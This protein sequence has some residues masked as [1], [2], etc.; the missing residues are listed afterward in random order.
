MNAM[1]NLFFGFLLFALSHLHAQDT[2]KAQQLKEVVLSAGRIDLP[3]SEHSRTIEIISAADI[4]RAAATNLADLLQ[5]VVGVDI[6]RRGAGGQQADLYIRGGSFDQT[7]LLI[8]GIKVEDPQT[9]HHTLNMALPLVLIERIEVVKGPSARIFGQNAFTGAINIV[10]KKNLDAKGIVQAGAGSFSQT[11]GAVSLQLEQENS[12]QIFH[13][14]RNTSQ[15]YR[16]NTDFKNH[17]FFT[18]ATFNKAKLP[19]TVMATFLDRA[20]GANGFYATPT[21]TEQYEETQASLVSLQT[22][23]V[24]NAWTFTPSVFWKRNQDQYIY[25]RN[26]PSVYRNLHLSNKVGAALMATFQS[27]LGTTGMGLELAQVSIRSNNLGNR[28][29]Q[30]WNGFLEQRFSFL[31]QRLDVTPGVALNYFSDFN[32]HAFPGIDFGYR[33][34]EA[35]KTYANFGYTYRIPTYTDL[36]YEDSTTIGNENLAPEDAFSWELGL[37]YTA[38]KTKAAAAFFSRA[39]ENLI[40]YVKFE[41]TDLWAAQNFAALGTTGF[42]ISFL[43]AFTAFGLPQKITMGYT[44]IDDEI[45]DVQVPF[46]RYAINSLKHQWNT[47]ASMNIIS[48]LPATVTYRYMERTNGTNY[49]VLDASLQY[50]TPSFVWSLI[51]NNLLD[52][53]FSETN[54]VPAPG[55]N[56]MLSLQYSFK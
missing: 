19:I 6:R 40:D 5:S 12:D 23:L 47:T 9:G 31:N 44:Y 11:Q 46:S 24:K 39:T 26:N 30:Q 4:K 3:L 2:I 34:S 55:I 25:I 36:Y 35:F 7:L 51:G 41:Q 32:F 37:S 14:S 20:F 43:Q 29:R 48:R 8:D 45:K 13:F 33:M 52:E 38:K 49:R 28:D 27:G 22:K 1:K 50:E 54:L 21:A 15:G 53:T 17:N 10:T 42:E 56:V 16:Y 18:K